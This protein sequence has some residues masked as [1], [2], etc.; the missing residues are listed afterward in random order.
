VLESV[1][2]YIRRV[3]SQCWGAF[4][5]FASVVTGQMPDR[6]IVREPTGAPQTSQGLDLEARGRGPLK[7]HI[8]RGRK[9]QAL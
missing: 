4:A 1:R 7:V 2:K 5:L 8:W 3:R 9:V 6:S